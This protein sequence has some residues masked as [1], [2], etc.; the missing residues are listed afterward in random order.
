VVFLSV[1]IPGGLFLVFE[2]FTQ[3]L[4]REMGMRMKDVMP[5]VV[6][7]MV[8][9]YLQFLIVSIIYTFII[10]SRMWGSIQDGQTP[11]TTGKA[12]GYLF[13]PFFNI[14]WIFRAWGSFPTEYNKYVDRYALPTP[15]LSGGVFT[16]YPVLL[17]LTAFLYV[18]FLIV[19][20]AF[21]AIIS[22]TCD[23]VNALG[24]A[25]EERRN[26]VSR[27]PMQY[28]AAAIYR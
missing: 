12:I 22:K 27:S 5:G 21:I 26:A 15:K 24:S 10:L 9:S 20:F 18:P 8:L 2:N 1:V 19:P 13:I 25:V 16:F 14:Y 7:L 6:S 4:V 3:D 17:L 11:I 23:A 28:Q